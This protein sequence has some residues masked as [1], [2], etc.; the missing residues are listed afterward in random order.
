MN[1]SDGLKCDDAVNFRDGVNVPLLVNTW[2]PLNALEC[3]NSVLAVNASVNG[4]EQTLPERSGKPA[5]P[6]G[7]RGTYAPDVTVTPVMSLSDTHF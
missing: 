2:L 4:R 5:P 1:L 7:A 6:E 3:V